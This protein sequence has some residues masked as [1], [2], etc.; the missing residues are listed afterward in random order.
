MT[1]MARGLA[2]VALRAFLAGLVE[3]AGQGLE[4]HVN[5]AA[6]GGSAAAGVGVDVKDGG[7]LLD[8]V[9]DLLHGEVHEGEGSVLRSLHAAEDGAGVLLGEEALGNADEDEDSSAQW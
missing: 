2:E 5:K 6:V 8:D 3:R 7:V 4:R 1:S 9:D